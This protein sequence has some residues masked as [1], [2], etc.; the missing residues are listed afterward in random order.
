MKSKKKKMRNFKIHQSV[1]PIPF[2]FILFYSFS[3]RY[4]ILLTYL[5]SKI[6]IILFALIIYLVKINHL[7]FLP[8]QIHLHDQHQQH[9]VWIIYKVLYILTLPLFNS[10]A[11]RRR[12]CRRSFR[13]NVTMDRKYMEVLFVSGKN[14]RKKRKS[15]PFFPVTRWYILFICRASYKYEILSY[16]FSFLSVNNNESS[17]WN[18]YDF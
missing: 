14:E 5:V 17:T 7:S 6:K 9:H 15:T 2:Y 16:K 18:S 8:L 11:H 4:F 10:H 1:I 13:N 3:P 12:R